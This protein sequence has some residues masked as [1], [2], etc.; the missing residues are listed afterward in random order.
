MIKGQYIQNVRPIIFISMFCSVRITI[1]QLTIGNMNKYVSG[2]KVSQQGDNTENKHEDEEI[3]E[4]LHNI[5]AH[6]EDLV[7]NNDL[8]QKTETTAFYMDPQE[9]SAI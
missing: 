6:I 7:K 2:R 4:K 1:I 8:V 3:P 5:L 9:D